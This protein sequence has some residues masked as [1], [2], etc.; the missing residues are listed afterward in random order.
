MH[1]NGVGQQMN[2]PIESAMVNYIISLYLLDS[3]IVYPHRARFYVCTPY[4]LGTYMCMCMC[5][6]VFIF[7]RAGSGIDVSY[8]G[9]VWYGKIGY[10]VESNQAGYKQQS[11]SPIEPGL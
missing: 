6:Y 9:M 11:K 10:R 5:T 3:S 8:N 4:V 1:N 2:V 7:I